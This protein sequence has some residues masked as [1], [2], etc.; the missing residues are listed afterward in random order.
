MRCAFADQLFDGLATQTSVVV[1][2]MEG[3][4]FGQ[5][6]TGTFLNGGI[7]LQEGEFHGLRK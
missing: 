1:L 7:Q 3:E 4:E 2:A 5:G 6:K